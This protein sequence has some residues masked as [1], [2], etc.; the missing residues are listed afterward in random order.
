MILALYI[1]GDVSESDWRSASSNDCICIYNNR[2]NKFNTLLAN[3][4]GSLPQWHRG[5]AAGKFVLDWSLDRLH[6][7]VKYVLAN[8]LHQQLNNDF[9][10]TSTAFHILTQF[11]SAVTYN[12][13]VTLGLITSVPVSAGKL[14]QSEC[15]SKKTNSNTF[16]SFR[17]CFIWSKFCWHEIGWSNSYCH[18]V[19]F[20]YVSQ[21]LL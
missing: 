7:D 16:F 4:I 17:Y 8:F 21:I 18:W 10:S 11:S 2:F 9:V 5:Y 14:F 20:S 19:L 3:T 15:F 12:M 13:F 1:A 6:F